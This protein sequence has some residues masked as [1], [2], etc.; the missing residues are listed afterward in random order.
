MDE[1]PSIEESKLATKP[2]DP[3]PST[4][5]ERMENDPFYQEILANRTINRPVGD[6]IRKRRQIER[7]NS[8]RV[9]RSQPTYATCVKNATRIQDSAVTEKD[10]YRLNS[11]GEHEREF[12]VGK[13]RLATSGQHLADMERRR[14]KSYDSIPADNVQN[15]DYPKP[16]I[17][18]NPFEMD[19]G[20]D[21]RVS[22]RSDSS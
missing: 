7:C 12:Y 4:I 15:Y 19:L 20:Y 17:T 6:H 14:S 3:S 18:S 22:P 8:E 1:E 10:N 5:K 2:N 9:S 16:M 11:E 21:Y 13:R